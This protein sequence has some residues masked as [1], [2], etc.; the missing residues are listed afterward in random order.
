LETSAYA[1]IVDGRLHDASSLMA[2]ADRVSETVGWNDIGGQ[3]IMTRSRI[4]YWSGRWDEAL[5]LAESGVV[6]L[7]FANLK[8]N[9]LMLRVLEVDILIERGDVGRA[10]EILATMRPEQV[11][12]YSVLLFEVRQARMKMRQ[13]RFAD[14]EHALDGAAARARQI[15]WLEAEHQ[16]LV[17]LVDCCISQGAQERA[18]VSVLRLQSLADLTGL[19]HIRRAATLATSRIVGSVEMAQEVLD[20]SRVD[21]LVPL[22]LVALVTIATLPCAEDAAVQLAFDHA[23]R[24]GAEPLARLLSA[25]GRSRNITLSRAKQDVSNRSQLTANERR[26]VQLVG[27]G[28]SNRQI[29]DVLHYSRKTV[30]AYLSRLYRKTG[31][32]SR[33]ALLGAFRDGRGP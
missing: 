18:E 1:A 11:S 6:K 5:H 29:A 4:S 26:L 13:A 32:N 14:A 30:E 2:C 16:A 10:K 17:S 27:D 28:L 8:T 3:A 22:E 7:E 15:G 31:T 24:L 21:G 25:V 12:P 33:M 23:N 20:S 19:E 9:L